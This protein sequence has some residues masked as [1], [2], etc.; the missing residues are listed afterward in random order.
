MQDLP[1]IHGIRVRIRAESPPVGVT[2]VPDG[3]NMAFTYG[4]SWVAFDAEPLEIHSVYRI[5]LKA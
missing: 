1:T 2:S 4:D 3:K 5:E